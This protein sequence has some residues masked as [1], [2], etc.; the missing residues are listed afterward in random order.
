MQIHVCRLICLPSKLNL[1]DF[2]MFNGHNLRHV[3]VHRLVIC[4]AFQFCV[5]LQRNDYQI[6]QEWTW[7][8]TRHI[9]MGNDPC[10]D[11]QQITCQWSEMDHFNMIWMFIVNHH[12]IRR[13]KTC[14]RSCFC[15]LVWVQ[16][17]SWDEK[18][19]IEFYVSI[20]KTSKHK[21]EPN[22]L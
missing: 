16:H 2:S 14:R 10:H 18:A 3:G 1:W 17:G 12:H 8:P 7:N 22:G 13:F 4:C 11:C 19:H 20:E 6:S 15:S 21:N 5:F 9:V